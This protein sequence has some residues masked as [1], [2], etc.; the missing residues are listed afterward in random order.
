MTATFCQ[1]RLDLFKLVRDSPEKKRCV[2]T[3]GYEG[4][5]V[6]SVECDT[7]GELLY[8]QGRDV[9]TP[10]PYYHAGNVDMCLPC[11][12][13][14]ENLDTKTNLDESSPEFEAVVKNFLKA[15]GSGIFDPPPED[16][17]YVCN[18]PVVERTQRLLGYGSFGNWCDSCYVTCRAMKSY[19]T[20]DANKCVFNLATL[21]LTAQELWKIEED[22]ALKLIVEERQRHGI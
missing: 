10:C 9:E 20:R 22:E 3:Q 5:P 21:H 7:C 12:T 2:N 11:F 15:Q 13:F 8:T 17:C 16:L 6:P 19:L 4:I 1:Q 18:K 14:Y